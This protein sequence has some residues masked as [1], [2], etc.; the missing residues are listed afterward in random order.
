MKS[1]SL[2]LS[3]VILFLLTGCSS[4]QESTKTLYQNEKAMHQK[5][6]ASKAE[7]ELDKEIEKLK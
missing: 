2:V 4:K 5:F 6:G 1:L 7:S 3:A